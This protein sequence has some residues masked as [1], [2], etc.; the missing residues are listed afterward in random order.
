MVDLNPDIQ[1]IRSS[2]HREF[3]GGRFGSAH[4]PSYGLKLRILCSRSL[5]PEI[6]F[7]SGW[8]QI[9]LPSVIG[10]SRACACR[11]VDGIHDGHSGPCDAASTIEK[12]CVGA[13]G[14]F[15]VALLRA[16]TMKAIL[17]RIEH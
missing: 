5:P 14:I 2:N 15:I 8:G 4:E 3:Q 10:R 9:S 6:L 12:N 7:C 1:I 16:V 11:I 17:Q 13:K